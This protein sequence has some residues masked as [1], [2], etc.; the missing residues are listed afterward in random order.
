[1]PMLVLRFAVLALL[2]ACFATASC[3]RYGLE[4]AGAIVLEA[5]GWFVV[6]GAPLLAPFLT[7]TRSV[8]RASVAA[9]LPL[10]IAATTWTDRDVL[11]SCFA[12]AATVVLVAP[13]AVVVR[14]S[15]EPAVTRIAVSAAIAGAL[16]PLAFA[17]LLWWPETGSL[18]SVTGR[19]WPTPH[20]AL[21]TAALAAALRALERRSGRA[22][23]ALALAAVAI[24]TAPTL[25]THGTGCVAFPG[26]LELV[27]WPVALACLALAPWV[28]PI[29]RHLRGDREHRVLGA[30]HPT[31]RLDR[32][33]V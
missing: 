11:A 5:P 25:G 13:L 14:R 27:R 17:T 28:G 23:L 6:L 29:R 19:V 26:P 21:A 7:S 1:M 12:I 4:S 32:R 31:R 15:D 9:A 2:A 22:L 33:S 8:V 20:V 3:A 18:G 10:P 16:L 30:H 24:A